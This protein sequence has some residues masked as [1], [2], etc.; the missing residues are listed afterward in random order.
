MKW[1]DTS[2]RAQADESVSLVQQVNLQAHI[3][4]GVFSTVPDPP[5]NNQVSRRLVRFMMKDLQAGLWSVGL[6]NSVRPNRLP[7][8]DQ[9]HRHECAC[10]SE[11][12]HERYRKP[13]PE[14]HS[15]QKPA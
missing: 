11:E 15:I 14:L 10:Q 9:G 3:V 4:P 2:A 13:E 12:Q 7:D 6:A 8:L 1:P 5:T